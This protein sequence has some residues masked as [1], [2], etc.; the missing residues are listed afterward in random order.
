M[1]FNEKEEVVI[2]TKDEVKE[3]DHNTLCEE[4][5][6]TLNKSLETVPSLSSSP[7]EKNIY[8]RKKWWE[9]WKQDERLM[10]INPLDFS[11]TQKNLILLTI[12]LATLV[13]PISTTIYTPALITIQKALDTNDTAMNATLSAFTFTIAICPLFWSV[14]GEVYGRR[15]VYLISFLIYVVG[16]VC[17]TLSVNIEMFIAF[18]VVTAIGSSSVLS[19]GAGTI[20]DVFKPT[21][22]GTAYSIYSCGPLLGPAL[23]PIIG[24]YLNLSLGW[25]STLAFVAIYG[26]IIW[27]FILFFLPETAR[28][29]PTLPGQE[30]V[31]PKFRNPFSALTYFRYM[32]V[33]LVTIYS[34]IVF[35]MYYLVNTTFSRTLTIQYHMDTG[36]IGLCYL[37]L[38]FG[39]MIGNQI[40]GRFSDYI[41]KK[42][43][44][45]AKQNGQEVYPE[46]RISSGIILIAA[47]FASLG[48]I[49]YGWVI[50]YQFHYAY[51]L[52]CIFFLAIGLMIPTLTIATYMID[53]FK[54]KASAVTA[55]ISLARFALGG[56]GSLVSSDL[57]R[58]LHG[59]GIT[60]SICGGVLLLVSSTIFYAKYNPKKWAAQRAKHEK[61]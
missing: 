15:A 7:I 43:S 27:L 47:I 28:P 21:E 14:L 37:P 59:D 42:N 17:C 46:M 24:G 32:N 6:P 12:A 56:V 9:F 31:K 2:I 41:F 35:L 10:A 25:R 23:G 34:G 44:E 57:I 38:A 8:N 29:K 4:N 26:F 36:T 11:K 40:G 19:M 58:A 20:Q 22:R 61:Q 1:A 52:I 30:P 53:S 49:A 39:A 33:V 48:F 51:A 60:F 55:C 16:C 50:Q 13:A 18:R 45:A 54:S 5:D 3:N